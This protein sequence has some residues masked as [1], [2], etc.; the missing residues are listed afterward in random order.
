MKYSFFD[1][2]AILGWPVDNNFT[3]S[4]EKGLC[5]K[6]ATPKVLKLNTLSFLKM[7]H[8]GAKSAVMQHLEGQQL[9]LV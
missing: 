3:V 6:G 7:S 8:Q 9:L 5:R 1:T 2:K 4:D